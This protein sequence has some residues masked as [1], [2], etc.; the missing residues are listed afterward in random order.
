[1]IDNAI[2]YIYIYFAIFIFLKFFEYFVVLKRLR[3][4]FKILER[5]KVI[6]E[7]YRKPMEFTSLKK[8]FHEQIFAK[9]RH[10]KIN[11]LLETRNL[12]LANICVLT[13]SLKRS[14]KVCFIKRHI[15]PFPQSL[16]YCSL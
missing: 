1:M 2:K 15:F 8:V 11:L 4:K 10:L 14:A 7:R 9:S 12:K 13:R 5:V 3:F 16:V 6:F